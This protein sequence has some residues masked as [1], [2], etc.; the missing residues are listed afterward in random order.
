MKKVARYLPD[1]AGPAR[2]WRPSRRS[3]NQTPYGPW[4]GLAIMAVWVVVALI[5][6]YVV[7]KQRDA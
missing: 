7:L 4:A 5:G 1:Q 3:D 6:G 2:S